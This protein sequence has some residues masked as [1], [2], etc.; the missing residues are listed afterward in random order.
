MKKYLILLLIVSFTISMLYMGAGCK[1]EAPTA[2][3]VAEEAPAEEE[4]VEEAVAELVLEG[5]GLAPETSETIYFRGWQFRTDVVESN[6]ARYNSEMGGNIDYGT[7]TGDYPT[8]MELQLMANAPLD[9][10]YGNPSSA[11]RYY[12]AGW[13]TSV[14]SLPNIEEIKEAMYPNLLDAWTY[15]GEL[16]G[17]NYFASTV[18]ILFVN[19]EKAEEYGITEADFPKTWDELYAQLPELRDKGIET[20][21]LPWWFSQWNGIGW[22]FNWEVLNRGGQIA[23]PE[24]HKAMMTVD[25]PAGETLRDWKEIFNAGLVPREVL[26][27][28]EAD[29]NHAWASGEFLYSPSNLSYGLQTFNEPGGSA[30]AGK[31]GV[32]PYQ[33]Q[34]WGLIDSGMYLMT[35]R[36]RSEGLTRDLKRFLSWY[37]YRD[38]Q[39]DLAVSNR[40][41][42]ESNA[43]S[44]YK[45]V[46]ESPENQERFAKFAASPEDYANILE[47]YQ[48]TP[49]PKGTF[50]VIWADEFNSFSKETLL[51]FLAEDRPVDETINDLNAKI[52]ELNQLYGLE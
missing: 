49:Y 11:V 15:K 29:H 48:N 26:T 23:D 21:Y 37:G 27:Y 3:E 40:W 31:C 1:K 32:V 39:G 42:E 18:G 10:I 17:L 8:I 46:M 33:G 30:F 5:D 43:Y 47:I 52:T 12:D 51:R 20:P 44:A 6:V 28:L 38:Q 35:N 50:S 7:V 13:I 36:D 45:E 9:L 22:C 24:T 41:A 14:E 4:V 19:L 34:P 16:L 25:G 2:E